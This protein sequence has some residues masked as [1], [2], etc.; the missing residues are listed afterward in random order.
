MER[1][2]WSDS[3]KYLKGI[4]PKTQQR[5]SNLGIEDIQDL[6]FHF[7]FR[8]DDIQE[9]DIET[10]LDGEKVTLRGKIVSSP[11][12]SYFGGRK[13]R[14]Q[15]RLSVQDSQVIAVVFF[16]QPYL[17]KNIQ[18]G[19]EIAIY[20]KWQSNRQSLLG[21]KI[22]PQKSQGDSFDPIYST[23]KGLKQNQIR[24][25]IQEAFEVANH[26]V[27]ELLPDY[28]ND[29][30]R[31]IPL[32]DA[33]YQM[34][35][36]KDSQEFMAAERK[37]IYLEFF[38]YQWRLLEAKKE[39]QDQAGI[40][41]LYDNDKL[42]DFIKQLP[43]DLTQSQKQVV[44]EICYDLRAAYPMRRMLQGDVGSGKT[45]VAFLSMIAA[46][47]AGYQVA[48][49]VP[50][51]ILAIQH[52]NSFNQLFEVMNLRAELLTGT[53]SNQEKTQ[54]SQGIESGRIRLI[55]GTHALI[56]KSVNFKNL[57][58][59]IIDEQHR[60]GVNQRQALMDKNQSDYVTNVLQMTATPIPRSLAQTVYG[61][62]HVSTIE[63]LPSGRLPIITEWVNDEDLDYV[64]DKMRE[65]LKLGHQIYYILPLIDYSEALE[66][67]ENVKAKVE[68]LSLVF[69][70]YRVAAIHGQLAKQEA[71]DVMED[72]KAN[73]INILVAT[74][75]VEVGVDVPN[76]TIIVIQAAERFGLAQLHQ[77]RGR[78]GRS[79]LQSYCYL[80]ASPTTDQGKQRL[81]IMEKENNGFKISEADLQ[82]RGMGDIMGQTQSG[83]PQFHYANIFEDHL[84][85][86]YARKD[87][88]TLQKNLHLLKP[89]ELA[90][91][92]EWQNKFRILI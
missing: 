5:F 27:M 23:V 63:T 22:L 38:Y 37:I 64:Y 7:P 3:I 2:A 25:S 15:F 73:K 16:N 29:K 89:E 45:I 55:I 56:Q 79:N 54:V 33:L 66:D 71:M 4:G 46:V 91:I 24:K 62:M 86:Q 77:L 8:Y 10:I 47:L 42:R 9:R 48:F 11:A 17:A 69:R 26:S 88:M 35:F 76:A 40:K 67:I 31:F 78:V 6:M 51:E 20:G 68:L 87:V 60:F 81:G 84:I 72:F 90:I 85:H 52:C 12:V 13:S 14:L 18:L 28:I 83:V 41:V 57:G 65:Q 30:Y 43:Y 82:I 32:Q 39:N 50:T 21:M 75:M 19:Q 58:L 59:V 80:I 36:P 70:D 44:N 53:L 74:T 34:H 1:I 61:D 92:R 49:M